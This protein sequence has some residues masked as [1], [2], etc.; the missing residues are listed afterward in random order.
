M[1]PYSVTTG[2]FNG[3]GITDL[4]IANQAVGMISVLL[5]VGDGT[6][7]LSQAFDVGNRP[8]VVTTGDFHGDP[9]DRYRNLRSVSK[10][11]PPRSSSSPPPP[12]VAS[13]REA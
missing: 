8:N 10:P 13:E 7:G 4:A 5:G 11:S 12:K 6:F 2:D 3:D 1:A 9:A